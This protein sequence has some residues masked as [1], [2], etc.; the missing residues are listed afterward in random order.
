MVDMVIQ[1]GDQEYGSERECENEE[2]IMRLGGWADG[3][4]GM[5]GG[6]IHGEMSMHV[7]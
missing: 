1:Q 3:V 4:V 5:N 7:R 2:R 6:E